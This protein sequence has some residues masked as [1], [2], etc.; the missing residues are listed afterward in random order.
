MNCLPERNRW[1]F[2]EDQPSAIN[3]RNLQFEQ[4]PSYLGGPWATGKRLFTSHTAAKLLYGGGWG[5]EEIKT[6]EKERRKENKDEGTSGPISFP[7]LSSSWSEWEKREGLRTSTLDETS[8][9]GLKPPNQMSKSKRRLY[10]PVEVALQ[11][12]ILGKYT[13][14]VPFRPFDCSSYFILSQSPVRKDQFTVF[15]LR[16]QIQPVYL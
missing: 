9:F 14:I 6:E 10:R 3:I 15:P 7:L 8:I 1:V 12:E 2:N 5:D 11:T 16:I 13:Y 4:K